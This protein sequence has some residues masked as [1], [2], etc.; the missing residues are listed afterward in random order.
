MQAGARISLVAALAIVVVGCKERRGTSDDAASGSGGTVAL[1][2]G[3][4]GCP[5]SSALHSSEVWGAREKKM[6]TSPAAGDILIEHRREG[7][8]VL[9]NEK[10]AKCTF[11]RIV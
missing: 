5:G 10:A 7:V 6:V 3:G 8:Y 2:G 1:D 4:R 9:D 11:I